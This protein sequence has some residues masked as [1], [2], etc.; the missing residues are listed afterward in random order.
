MIAATV[1]PTVFVNPCRK[2]TGWL[3]RS[4]S[5]G[6]TGV[7]TNI[8]IIV[9]GN[10]DSHDFLVLLN[11]L[12]DN[13]V[14]RD[15]LCCR[16]RFWFCFWCR[17][18]RCRKGRRS[19]DDVQVGLNIG[20]NTVDYLVDEICISVPGILKCQVLCLLKFVVGLAE[21]SLE[22]DPGFLNSGT[23]FPCFNVLFKD[24][25]FVENVVGFGYYLYLRVCV[26]SNFSIVQ[27][28]FDPIENLF[29]WVYRVIGHLTNFEV[30]IL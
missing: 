15:V 30:E 11:Q 26:A 25:G 27:E 6:G 21:M 13:G 14:G 12:I 19:L 16:F 2:R 5:C 20:C 23:A 1:G 29:D 4:G 9:V 28:I 18:W 7:M 8:A 24:T 3:P 10:E 17:W 22:V